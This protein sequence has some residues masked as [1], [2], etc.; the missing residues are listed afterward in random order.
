MAHE[1]SARQYEDADGGDRSCASCKSSKPEDDTT[2][3][4]L[5]QENKNNNNNNNDEQA[6]SYIQQSIEKD[7]RPQHHPSSSKLS[8]NTYSG[9]HI[10]YIV[11]DTCYPTAHSFKTNIGTANITSVHSTKAAAKSRAKKIIYENDGG[12]TVDIEKIIEEV[13]QGLYTGIG[14]GGKEEKEGCC[15]ARK[16]EVE[17]KI[18]DEDSDGEEGSGGSDALYE[19]A[20]SDAV[21]GNR[22][23]DLVDGDQDGDVEM[24]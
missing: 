21:D 17:G 20:G 8:A 18:V 5:E 14:V 7:D 4:Q 12:C 2:P 15:F 10:I 3:T 24:G 22:G 16:C 19:S 6:D 9:P 13:K 11:V 23:S 1:C